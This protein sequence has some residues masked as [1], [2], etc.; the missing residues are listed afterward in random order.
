[1]I[2]LRNP[3]KFEKGAPRAFQ[4]RAACHG[5]QR[6]GRDDLQPIALYVVR[7]ISVT[8]MI[9]WSDNR[10]FSRR[11]VEMI[12]ALSR[13]DYRTLARVRA[14]FDNVPILRHYAQRN[15][16]SITMWIESEREKEIGY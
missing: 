11:Y 5:G 3:T 12:G 14:I 8:T 9:T 15:V 6:R 13:T 16:R 7:C 4:R 2:R 10:C 1:M